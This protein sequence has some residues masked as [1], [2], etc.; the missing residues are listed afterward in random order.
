MFFRKRT[1]QAKPLFSL[2]GAQYAGLLQA[3]ALLKR[4]R[5]RANKE[6][7]ETLKCGESFRLL[8]LYGVKL[9]EVVT[10]EHIDADKAKGN[11]RF[12]T[13]PLLAKV[14]ISLVSEETFLPKVSSD[15]FPEKKKILRWKPVQGSVW[16]HWVRGDE[17]S[18]F[19]DESAIW[20]RGADLEEDGDLPLK[21]ILVD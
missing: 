5:V 16:V 18:T 15:G 10:F 8:D 1:P 11:F 7:Q 9:T 21:V 20:I 17:Y 14:E 13:S 6:E 3:T 2:Q 19:A 12:W 4:I